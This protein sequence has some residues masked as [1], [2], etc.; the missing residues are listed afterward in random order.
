MP[1]R[2]F[3]LLHG[4]AEEARGMPKAY[5]FLHQPG[6]TRV[7]QDMRRH[8]RAEPRRP[9]GCIETLPNGDVRA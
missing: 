1:V 5:P 8:I 9:Y 4:H 3:E 7:P 6:R 2:L